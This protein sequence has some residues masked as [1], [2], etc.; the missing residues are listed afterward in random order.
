[1]RLG[2]VISDWRWANRMGVR[3]AAKLIGV[4]IATLSRVECGKNCDGDT[5]AKIV[6]WL[7]EPA[8][9]LERRR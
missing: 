9:T 4:S 7:I 2:A 6:L 8:Q 5:L 3:E 1:M